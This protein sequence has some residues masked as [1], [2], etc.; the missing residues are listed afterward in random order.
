V[1]ALT[2][3]LPDGN[4]EMSPHRLSAAFAVTIALAPRISIT[5]AQLVDLI[6]RRQAA[7]SSDPFLD[8]A[9]S[10]EPKHVSEAIQYRSLD[11]RGA[12]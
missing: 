7:D 8:G 3:G 4:R 2:R 5:A 6:L 9:A 12:G 1:D 11:R 10:P